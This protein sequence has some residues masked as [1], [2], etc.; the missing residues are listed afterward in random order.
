MLIAQQIELKFQS[1]Y[2]YSHIIDSHILIYNSEHFQ[3]TIDITIQL[4]NKILLLK[5]Y[6]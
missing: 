4:I 5:C 3:N 6:P 1:C 2:M